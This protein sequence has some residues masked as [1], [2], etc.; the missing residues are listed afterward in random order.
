MD[1]C[2]LASGGTDTAAAPAH[3]SPQHAG[4]RSGDWLAVG[5]AQQGRDA[6]RPLFLDP[7]WRIVQAVGTIGIRGI[8]VRAISREAR[9]LYLA[10]GFEPSALEP[11][12]P[13]ATLAE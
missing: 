10:P 9:K 13:I 7:R 11:M 5:T 3:F 4:P 8:P 6:G 12:A 1:Y 2:A